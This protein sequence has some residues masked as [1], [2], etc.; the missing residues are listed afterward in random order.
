[1]IAPGSSSEESSSGA[2]GVR[3]NVT[4]RLWR[5]HHGELRSFLRRRVGDPELAEDLL[6]IVFVKAHAGLGALADAERVRPWLYRIARNAAIDHHRT[7]RIGEPLPEDLPE[8]PASEGL[9]PGTGLD[10]CVRP[11]IDQMPD[12]YR[13][14]LLL[15]DIEGLPLREVAAR[16]RLSLS[17]AKS[18]VQR[19]RALLGRSFQTCCEFELDGRGK[20]IGWTQRSGGCVPHRPG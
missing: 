7:R 10:R 12:R 16:L 1:M 5:D 13:E 2:S 14:A 4:E 6:Q 15:A 19:G 3:P 20:P 17:G 8:A 18:R 9:E 11:L